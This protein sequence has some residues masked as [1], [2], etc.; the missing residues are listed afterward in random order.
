MLISDP[1]LSLI[2]IESRLDLEAESIGWWRF[3]SGLVL[4]LKHTRG[5]NLSS[6]LAWNCF[7]L[8]DDVVQL[9]IVLQ[10]L[11]L[12]LILISLR[13]LLELLWLILVWSLHRSISIIVC[14]L[15]VVLLELRFLVVSPDFVE[16]SKVLEEVILVSVQRKDLEDT[17]H[18]VVPVLNKHVEEGHS[19]VLNHS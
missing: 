14:V 16:N 18:F 11:H 6:S 1:S 9:L 10:R 5:V 2:L 3:S 8:V 17:D 15:L 19:R 12:H 4:K 13:A 7:G